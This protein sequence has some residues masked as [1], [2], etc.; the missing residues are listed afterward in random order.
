MCAPQATLCSPWLQCGT[1]V[2][3]LDR[4]LLLWLVRTMPQLI[5]ES[6]WAPRTGATLL[7]CFGFLA[8]VLAIVGI[9]G[10]ISYSVNQRLRD[11][12]I[13]MALGAAPVQILKEVL[14]DGFAVVG[15]G[16]A[17]ELVV[18]CW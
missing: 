2:Q 10:V 15:A 13:R 9:Y 17:A 1:E 3:A 6:L 16:I 12:G 18:P 4:N 7:S 11:I 5:E 14:S 8:L